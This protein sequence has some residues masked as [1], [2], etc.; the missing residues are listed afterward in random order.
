MNVYELARKVHDRVNGGD[1]RKFPK[2]LLVVAELLYASE[3]MNY[4]GWCTCSIARGDSD[5]DII[6]LCGGYDDDS[7]EENN[8]LHDSFN[9]MRQVIVEFK[10]SVVKGLCVLTLFLGS[11]VVGCCYMV[12][13]QGVWFF[14]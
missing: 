12:F 10:P 13:R 6:R 2:T 9:N 8:R 4:L 11:A 5:E 1:E 14:R 3:P 7:L